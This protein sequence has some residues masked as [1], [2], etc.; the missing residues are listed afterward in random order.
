[1]CRL[2]QEGYN[3]RLLRIKSLLYVDGG[4]KANF[5]SIEMKVKKFSST[6]FSD[7]AHLQ[8]NLGETYPFGGYVKDAANN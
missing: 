5:D 8:R 1:M 6:P 7:E 3:R 4:M 2:H